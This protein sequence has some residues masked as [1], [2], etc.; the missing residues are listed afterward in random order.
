[1]RALHGARQID[2]DIIPLPAA[3][4]AFP[5]FRRPLATRKNEKA[6]QT[7]FFLSL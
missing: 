6:G 2:L 5:K 4:Y 3:D 7:G 1:M